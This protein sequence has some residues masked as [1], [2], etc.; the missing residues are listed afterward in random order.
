MGGRAGTRSP[1]S[2]RSEAAAGIVA[3]AE[4]ERIE[5]G[6]PHPSRGRDATPKHTQEGSKRAC[7]PLLV[8]K[9]KPFP[10]LC[11]QSS[12]WLALG[13]RDL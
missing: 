6:K 11:E 10:H 7:T 13:A 1:S 12:L 8:S 4:A 2:V 5:G 9:P 3:P